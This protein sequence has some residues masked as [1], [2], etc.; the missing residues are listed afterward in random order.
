[1][2][3]L[4]M[5]FA[6][7]DGHKVSVSLRHAKET[8]NEE[9]VRDAMQTVIDIQALEPAVTSIVSAQLIDRV[10]TDIVA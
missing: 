4:R 6:R 2:K 3:T 1:M 10:V 9:D 7:T 5:T 8:Q